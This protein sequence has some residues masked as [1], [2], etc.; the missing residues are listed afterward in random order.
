MSSEGSEQGSGNKGDDLDNQLLRSLKRFPGSQALASGRGVGRGG[1]ARPRG[2]GHEA[3]ALA[4]DETVT[5]L[6]R[7][8]RRY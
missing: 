2:L 4:I 7:S 6:A 8:I 3:V 5:L 1:V